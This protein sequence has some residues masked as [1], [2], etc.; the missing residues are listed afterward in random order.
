MDHFLTKGKSRSIPVT[1]VLK[2]DSLSVVGWWGPRPAD[3]QQL[4]DELKAAHTDGAVIKEKL[5]AWYGKDNGMSTAAEFITALQ[6]AFAMTENKE[7][8]QAA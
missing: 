3:A 6:Q 1:I 7:S 4:I 5:H 8:H 2:A